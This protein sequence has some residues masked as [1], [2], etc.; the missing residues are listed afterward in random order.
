[1]SAQS[2]R[3]AA[4]RPL[5]LYRREPWLAALIVAL[6]VMVASLLLPAE[7]RRWPM[8]AAS[9]LGAGGLLLLIFHRPHPEADQH[10]RAVG[11]PDPAREA[12]RADRGRASADDAD[13]AGSPTQA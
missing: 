5:P 8:I 10:L 9:V 3:A 7:I 11:A 12:R 13:Q 4:E 1:M 2:H 6:L